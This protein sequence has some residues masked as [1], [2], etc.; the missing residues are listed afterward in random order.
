MKFLFLYQGME[1][2]PELR[3]AWSAWFASLDGKFLDSG[4]PLGGGRTVT[5]TGAVD[6]P[7]TSDAFTGYSLVTADSLAQAEEFAA[8]CPSVE[9]VRIYPALSM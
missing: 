8:S 7:M 3:K 1:D 5:A 4:S 9:G 6:A 2:T